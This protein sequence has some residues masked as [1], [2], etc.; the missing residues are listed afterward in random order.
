MLKKKIFNNILSSLK[1]LEL[2]YNR[3]FHVEIPNIAEHGDYSTN[4][5]MVISKMNGMKPRELAEKLAKELNKSKNYKSVEI[6]GPGFINFK[7]SNSLYHK[8]LQEIIKAKDRFGSSDYGKRKKILLEFISANPTGPLNVVSARAGAYGDSLARIMEFVGFE[9]FKEFYVNDA[10]NQVEILG[11]SME[12]RYRELHGDDMEEFPPEAYHGEY[13]KDL[14]A[15]LNSIDG[16]KLFHI[17][18]KDRLERMQNFAL[19]EIHKMQVKSLERFDVIFDNWMSE[20]KLRLEGMLEEALSYLAEAHCT[21]EKEDAVWFSSTQFGDEKDRVL[22]KTDG[23]PTY[24]VPDIAYHITKFQRGFDVLVDVLGP[25]HHGHVS[26][27]RAALTALELDLS[28]LEIVYLQHINLIQDGETVKMSKRAGKIVTLDDL[29][30]EVG[31]D[32]ARYFFVN[33]KPSAHLDFDLELAKKKSSE[34]PVYYC[35]YAH[36]RIASVIKKA[37][38]EKITLKDFDVKNLRK[39]NKDSELTLIKKM[40][41]LPEILH[42]CADHREPHRL[43][44]YTHELAGMLHKYYAKYQIVNAKHKELSQSRLYLLSAIK[45]VLAISLNLLGVTAKDK[46]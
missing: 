36:A 2:R 22:I 46:M 44:G 6:A 40:L 8:S 16:S 14:A 31:K 41:N 33:R 26:K 25:D 10:G 28:K 38:K 39:L 43:A 13:I 19:E 42:A 4:V 35:Q 32:A 7:L 23:N 3:K 12:I 34:N 30:D 29:I 37:K 11:E 18:E 27:L 20:K 21:Y 9:P 15:Q 1:K 24:L 45:S 5:A 17:A